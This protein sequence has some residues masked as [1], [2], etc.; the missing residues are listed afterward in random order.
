MKEYTIRFEYPA[1]LGE[2]RFDK[3]S[4]NQLTAVFCLKSNA[5]LN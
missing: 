1:D 3:V 4:F 5:N 2:E